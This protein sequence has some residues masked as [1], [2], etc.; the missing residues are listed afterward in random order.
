MPESTI[1]S[2]DRRLRELYAQALKEQ[3]A[4]KLLS[5]YQEIV[6]LSAQQKKSSR[7]ARPAM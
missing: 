3:D 4:G 6:I 2:D 5:L 7:E 1:K